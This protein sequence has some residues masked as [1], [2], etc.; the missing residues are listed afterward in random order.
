METVTVPQLQQTAHGAL[1]ATAAQVHIVV[2]P[3]RAGTALD[4][5]R[6]QQ[7]QPLRPH[8]RAV[9]QHQFVVDLDEGMPHPLALHAHHLGQQLHEREEQADGHMAHAAHPREIAPRVDMPDQRAAHPDQGQD[10]CPAHQHAQQRQPGEGLAIVRPGQDEEEGQS[11]TGH[12]AGGQHQA[13]EDALAP[14]AVLTGGQG[15]GRLS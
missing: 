7:E 14:A 6:Q 9:G 12:A 10:A 3:V 1:S 8:A 15:I 4:A 11:Q 2:E 13:D 5:V